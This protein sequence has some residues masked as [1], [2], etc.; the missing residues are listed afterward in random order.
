MIKIPV[1]WNLYGKRIVGSSGIRMIGKER[2]EYTGR[3]VKA[4]N[5]VYVQERT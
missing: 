1:M 4:W 2:E 5:L 3:E